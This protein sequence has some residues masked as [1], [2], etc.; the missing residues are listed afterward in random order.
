ML[1]RLFHHVKVSTG[2]RRTTAQLC[3]LALLVAMS[4]VTLQARAEEYD[5]CAI[6]FT[7][8]SSTPIHRMVRAPGQWMNVALNMV[9]PPRTT[10]T[11]SSP[12]FDL[13]AGVMAPNGAVRFWVES[14]STGPEVALVPVALPLAVNVEA[15][16]AGAD[17]TPN[18]WG[19]APFRKRPLG[20]RLELG[21]DVPLGLLELFCVVV[22]TGVPLD[23]SAPNLW[24]N[25][26]VRWL[27]VVDP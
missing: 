21:R 7:Q 23:A 14:L 16:P 5:E 17:A 12:R 13:Y 19:N 3:A 27:L 25:S 20:V 24:R 18:W 10:R 2:R 8:L 9:P 22:P 1:R 26:S 15:R 4:L 6:W 11:A